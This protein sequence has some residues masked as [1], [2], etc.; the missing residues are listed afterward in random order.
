M[1]RAFHDASHGSRGLAAMNRHLEHQRMGNDMPPDMGL[2]KDVSALEMKERLIMVA[3]VD[4]A[5]GLRDFLL[6]HCS[7]KGIHASPRLSQI[8]RTR[9][10]ESGFPP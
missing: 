5:S 10:Q 6:E 2:A 9:P 1:P 8:P 3:L 7:V 4:Q